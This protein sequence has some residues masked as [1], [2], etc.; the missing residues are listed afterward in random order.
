MGIKPR[1]S[2]IEKKCH[3]WLTIVPKL[4]VRSQISPEKCVNSHL[5]PGL[6]LLNALHPG[7]V[8]EVLERNQGPRHLVVDL[9]DP[10]QE[11][12][13][14]GKQRYVCAGEKNKLIVNK[15]LPLSLSTSLHDI[16][17]GS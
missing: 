17:Q 8:P 4:P 14:P 10:G 12:G 6:G 11:E 13:F 2:S 3:P 7:L 15:R 9:F 5:E 1:A 16:L